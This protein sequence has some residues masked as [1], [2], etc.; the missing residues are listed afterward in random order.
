VTAVSNNCCN[1]V[2]SWD[3]ATGILTKQNLV[4]SLYCDGTYQIEIKAEH[5]AFTDYKQS[6]TATVQVR[7]DCAYLRS[8]GQY[9]VPVSG[10]L[11]LW[12]ERSQALEYSKTY[13]SYQI[14]A[15]P[16]DI[17]HPLIHGNLPFSYSCSVQYEFVC[18]TGQSNCGSF[19]TYFKTPT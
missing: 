9:A 1:V 11:V 10:Q 5:P 4:H 17:V 2:F 7:Y 18:P 8:Q 13:V 19:T 14:G 16:V 12:P 6:Y 15:L 3:S